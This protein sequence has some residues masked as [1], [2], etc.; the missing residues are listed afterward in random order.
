MSDVAQQIPGTRQVAQRWAN[1]D[2][3]FVDNVVARGFTPQEAE[4]IFAHY[5][6]HRI[7][8]LDMVGGTWS[9]QHGRYWDE[10][11]LKRALAAS[12]RP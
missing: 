12:A 1:A 10:E 3:N 6:K 8:K 4:R 5:R 9:V 11:I 7:I 2:Q